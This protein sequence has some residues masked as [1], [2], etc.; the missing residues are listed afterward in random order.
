[1]HASG[2]PTEYYLFGMK[3]FNASNHSAGARYY[4]NR[5]RVWM[6]CAY[7]LKYPRWSYWIMIGSVKEVFKIAVAEKNSWIKLTMMLLGIRDG[8]LMHMGKTVEL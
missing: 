2:Y 8:V 1:M 5:N 4:L 6:L 7:G 3:L